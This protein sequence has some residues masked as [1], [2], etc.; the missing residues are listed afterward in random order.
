[1]KNKSNI[2]VAVLIG[3]LAYVGG[4]GIAAV[5]E[6]RELRK[7]GV[8]A[9]LVVIFKKK[10][11]EWVKT[12][13][14]EDIPVVFLSDRLP[15]FFRL[16]FKIPGFSFFSF[17]HISSIF[18]APL[19]IGKYKVIIVHETYNCFS[20]IACAKLLNIKLLAYLWDPI[21]YIIPRIYKKR[22]PSFLFSTVVFI[23][24]AV[25][26][27]I[28]KNSDLVILGSGLHEKLIEEIL[29][30]Q[31]I[32]KIPVGTKVLKKVDFKREPL[33]VALT[34][35][36]KGKNPEFL[37]KIA[38]RLKNQF[39]FIIAGN[40]ADQ[41]Q[42][43]EFEH[44]IGRMRLSEK[45]F[46]VGKVTEEEKFKL[47]SQARV[48]VHPVVEAFGMMALESAGCGCPFIIPKGSGVTELFTDKEHGFFL[49]EGNLESFI[50]KTNLLLSSQKTSALMGQKAYNTAIAYSWESHAHQIKKALETVFEN[51]KSKKN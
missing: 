23:T 39:K 14:T 9:E 16:D 44:Q 36:D 40:W 7:L 1:M 2:K 51:E 22:I 21:S 30:S 11:F 20:A 4:V 43:K 32:V 27:F 26:R 46:V 50:E 31:K 17:F 15:R 48:L 5:N 8:E 13:G 37:L 3:Q 6:V 12:F 47:F 34:K 38:V 28:I 35:W 41:K 49:N 33:I 42:K 24:K 10:E 25:D 29:P 19:V 18:W 45:V